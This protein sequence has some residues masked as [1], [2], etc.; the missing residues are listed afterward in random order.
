MKLK[1]SHLQPWSITE[2]GGLAF[3][4]VPS[5]PHSA[6]ST[7]V[8]R[9]SPPR[10]DS[11]FKIPRQRII[12]MIWEIFEITIISWFRLP[13]QVLSFHSVLNLL[14]P[15]QQW[16]HLWNYHKRVLVRTIFLKLWWNSCRFSLPWLQIFS[17][18]LLI[19]CF[20]SASY[21][22]QLWTWTMQCTS[23]DEPASLLCFVKF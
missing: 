6:K 12:P 20:L 8:V 21:K 5:Y 16:H 13:H 15:S 14:F 23:N 17:K 18:V 19:P 4:S 10:A 22:R 3:R 1:S 9:P 7:L 11:S 2:Q